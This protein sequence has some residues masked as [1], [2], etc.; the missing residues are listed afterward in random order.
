MFKN[1]WWYT[2]ILSIF[3]FYQGVYFLIRNGGHPLKDE[4][5]KK[6][7]LPSK[8]I[9]FFCLILRLPIRQSFVFSSACTRYFFFL[10]TINN[11]LIRTG[12]P[13]GSRP[14]CICKITT[15]YTAPGLAKDPR[16]SSVPYRVQ[17][18]SS[19]TLWFLTNPV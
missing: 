3:C 5:S 16:K 14:L 8:K 9:L 6:T 18:N 10:V 15:K 7:P 11:V 1:K 19:Q 17:V 4:S 2:L 13:S 12:H